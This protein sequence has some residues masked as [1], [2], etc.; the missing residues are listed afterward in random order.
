MVQRRN[1]QNTASFLYRMYNEPSKAVIKILVVTDPE[2]VYRCSDG[3]IPFP[4][5]V[6][7]SSLEDPS[8]I[9]LLLPKTPHQAVRFSNLFF[10]TALQ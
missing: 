1:Q 8:L 10:L 3:W 2:S 5:S 7:I 4:L 9:L 6:A